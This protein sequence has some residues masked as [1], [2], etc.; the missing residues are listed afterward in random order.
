M[1]ESMGCLKVSTL[2]GLHLAWMMTPR[3]DG[4]LVLLLLET[5]ALP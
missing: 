3:V 5:L 2:K 1:S 4:A